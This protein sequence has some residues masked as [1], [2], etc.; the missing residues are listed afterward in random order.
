MLYLCLD[1]KESA[2][3][4]GDSV[5]IPGSRR[6]PGERNGNPLQCSCLENPVDRGA[7]LTERK[8]YVYSSIKQWSSVMQ[9]H[10]YFCTNLIYLPSA[11]LERVKPRAAWP[12]CSPILLCPITLPPA[13]LGPEFTHKQ[14]PHSPWEARDKG[15]LHAQALHVFSMSQPTLLP[16]SQLSGRLPFLGNLAPSCRNPCVRY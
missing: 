5:S 4:V 9:N 13:E 16:G 8:Q 2:C 12:G 10:N 11:F 7:W 15:Y 3:N 6:S 1:N 14:V